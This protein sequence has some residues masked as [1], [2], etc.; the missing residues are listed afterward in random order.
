MRK[1]KHLPIHRKVFS[2]AYDP[3]FSAPRWLNPDFARI[4][5]I[6][7]IVKTRYS[8]TTFADL[9]KVRKLLAPW[10]MSITRNS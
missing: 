2:A 10:I 8:A 5:N 4:C 7:V 3:E 1:L 9:E 6:K